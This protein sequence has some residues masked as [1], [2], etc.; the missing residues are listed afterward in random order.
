MPANLER[1]G[2]SAFTG[3]SVLTSLTLPASL[4]FIG[5][6]VFQ[7]CA[8][9]PAFTVTG[10]GPLRTGDDG[11][12]LIHNNVVVAAV[13]P[14]TGTVTVPEGVT[15]IGPYAFAGSNAAGA[16][17][18]TSVVMPA[19][20]TVI[21]EYAFSYCATLE[22][23]TFPENSNL[24]M[25]NTWA[26]Q[27]CAGLTALDFSNTKLEETASYVAYQAPNIERVILP[28]SIK[29]IGGFSF[30]NMKAGAVL[31]IHAVEPPSISNTSLSSVANT[32]AIKVPA[33]SVD[34]YKEA[35]IWS[36]Y[37]AKITA[38]TP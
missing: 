33:A 15:K 18:L 30:N 20:L 32:S 4:A 5:P 22:S 2:A 31:T 10:S 11:R 19:S 29:N 25:I 37:A 1:L 26:F 34:A 24:T 6:Q 17:K 28:A 27:Y 13:K 14:Y 3:M 12:L 9:L 36:T 8:A 7:G 23:V 38:I 35:D 21:D 16:A